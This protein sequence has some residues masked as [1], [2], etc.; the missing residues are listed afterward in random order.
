MFCPI[1][2]SA[3]ALPDEPRG[4]GQSIQAMWGKL[5]VDQDG[6]L[7]FSEFQSLPRLARLPEEKQRGLFERFDKNNDGSLTRGELRES[8]REGAQE[9][10]RRLMELD[11]DGS[12]GV[13]LEEFRKGEMFA[14]IDPKRIET[15][16]RRLD[17]DGDGEISPKDRPEPRDGQRKPKNWQGERP[18]LHRRIFE[19]LDADKSG[20]LDF[21]QFRQAHGPSAMDED[22]QEALFL[23]LD[24]DKDKRISLEEFSNAAIHEI[25]PPQR[26]H[27]E[28]REPFPNG[29]Q[30]GAS[31]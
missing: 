19:R 1:S 28:N 10:R 13:C 18:G 17:T 24:I 31:E 4:K 5:D 8:R 11:V 27:G 7:S 29:N 22:A 12:G 15:M 14:N 21:E 30:R 25:A 23:R 20:T 16:F 3:E 2:L 26:R 9:R 6:L